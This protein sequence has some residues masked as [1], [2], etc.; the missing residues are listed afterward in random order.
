MDCC[1]ITSFLFCLYIISKRDVGL[2]SLP[3]LAKSYWLFLGGGGVNGSSRILSYFPCKSGQ[4]L[5][6]SVEDELWLHNEDAN[7]TQVNNL[8]SR[9][10]AY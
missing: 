2:T 8:Q 4:V 5:R 9:L 6:G 3:Q 1:G 7:K 10:A